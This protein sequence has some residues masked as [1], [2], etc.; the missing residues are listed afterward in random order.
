M[1]FN[2]NASCSEKRGLFRPPQELQETQVRSLS[3]LNAQATIELSVAVAGFYRSFGQINE[4]LTSS[5]QPAL[6]RPHGQ[7]QTAEDRR[8]HVRRHWF[9]RF[10]LLKYL[11]PIYT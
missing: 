7:I 2:E 11:I 8:A 3:L 10:D 1:F 6:C 9:L 5:T 4:E